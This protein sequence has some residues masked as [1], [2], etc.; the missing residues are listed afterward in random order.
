[1][2]Y[3]FVA[4]NHDLDGLKFDIDS[5]RTDGTKCDWTR[6]ISVTFIID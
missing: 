6:R 2:S 4:A 1:M 3:R 5:N